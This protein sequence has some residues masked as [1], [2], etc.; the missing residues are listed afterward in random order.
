M[1]DTRRN[2]SEIVNRNKAFFNRT[3]SERPLL[4]I[5]ILGLDFMQAY[6]ETSKNIPRDTTAPFIYLK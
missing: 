5:Y 1:K 2:L 6:K 3:N 4:G